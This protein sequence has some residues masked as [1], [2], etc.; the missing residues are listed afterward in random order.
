[1]EYSFE[2]WCNFGGCHSGD[3]YIE[4]EV[5]EEEFERLE[6]ARKSGKSFYECK[7][8]A[9]LYERAYELA[10]EDATDSLIMADIIEKGQKA[11][12]LYS[13]GVDFDR[14]YDEEDEEEYENE[15]C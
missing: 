10:D 13:I 7:E 1:M 6:T 8:V 9:D 14:Y 11:S 3:S 12:D 4:M 2:C 5:T 15:E